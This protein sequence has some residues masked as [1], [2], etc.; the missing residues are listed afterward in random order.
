MATWHKDRV[1][2]FRSAATILDAFQPPKDG[3]YY[4]RLI[5]GFER[6]FYSTFYLAS[7]EQNAE[8][9]VMTRTIFRLVKDLRLWY[10]KTNDAGVSR[11]PFRVRISS[12]SPRNSGER[13]RSNPIPVDLSVVR[14]LADSRGTLDLYVWLTWRSWTAKGRTDIPRFGP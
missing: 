6:I 9:V 3:R 4:K 10:F 12:S 11:E 8:A 5:A 7:D 2:R 13:F 14:A 1:I